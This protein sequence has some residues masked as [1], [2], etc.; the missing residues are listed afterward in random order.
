MKKIVANFSR[1]WRPS[2]L[3][4][5]RWRRFKKVR[6]AWY[7]LIILGTAFFFSLLS[8]W[9]VN[10]EPFVMGYQGKLYFP[11][12]QFYTAMEFGGDYKTEA[13]YSELR[14]SDEFN[15][16]GWM[17]GPLIP[18]DPLH[19]DLSK[20]GAPPWAPS[21]QH[22]LGTDTN[23][24]DVLSR[25]IHGFRIC[26]V[27]SLSLTL[28]SAFGGIVIGGLQGL[29]GGKTDLL[30]QRG[31]EIWSALPFLYVVILISSIYGR[32]FS[33]LLFSMSLFSWI[34]L[35]YY[36]RGEFMKLRNMAYVKAARS[37][38]MGRFHIFFRELLP[39]ALN[40]AITILPFALIGGI[41]SLTALDFLGFGMPPPSPSWGELLS[42]GLSSLWAWWIT[43]STV[44]AL[45]VTLLLAT[46]IGEGV[47]D[48]MDPKSGDRYE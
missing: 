40:P 30:T 47:R 3:S 12:F 29:K 46:F 32:S 11:A 6:R 48:A 25:L 37:L 21:A 31:I 24:R 15:N 17:F 41:G 45:F 4:L 13:N 14:K 10:D 22:W 8:P 18:H 43:T 2:E 16:K 44:L 23:G 28:L 39:N 1:I 33:L 42:Q 7:A 19:A 38:G 9:L 36:M 27:F 5:D 20:E 35:S 34:G 26:M